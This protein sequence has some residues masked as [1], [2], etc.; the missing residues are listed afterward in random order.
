MKPSSPVASLRMSGRCSLLSCAAG[1]SQRA[2]NKPAPRVSYGGRANQIS[3]ETIVY[4]AIE[5]IHMATKLNRNAQECNSAPEPSQK[6]R[7]DQAA[8][9]GFLSDPFWRNRPKAAFGV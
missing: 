7:R 1:P 4:P 8:T 2:T 3:T 5:E 6:L 9:Y